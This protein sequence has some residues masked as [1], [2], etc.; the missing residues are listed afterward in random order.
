MNSHRNFQRFIKGLSSLAMIFFL[1][2]CAPLQPHWTD[3]T[4][5]ES[6]N[7]RVVTNSDPR[8]AELVLKEYAALLD[9][10]EQTQFSNLAS[11]PE[12]CTVYIFKN[13]RKFKE[14]LQGHRLSQK[15]QA[16]YYTHTQS[17]F[18]PSLGKYA[19]S[20]KSQPFWSTLRHEMVHHLHWSKINRRSP[21]W[22]SEG[23]AEWLTYNKT[24]AQDYLLT[25]F[26]DP[27]RSQQDLPAIIANLKA[28]I[29][30]KR[31]H[32]R[33][34]YIERWH[35]YLLVRALMEHAEIANRFVHYALFQASAHDS[36]KTLCQS[37][38]IS[39]E[40][41]AQIYKQSTRNSIR[42]LGHDPWV[43]EYL[44]LNKSYLQVHAQY[45]QAFLERARNSDPINHDK[46]QPLLGKLDQI[47]RRI[48]QLKQ[49]R[50]PVY[51][52][53]NKKR[54]QR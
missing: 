40:E 6:N 26:K 54:D 21:F 17:V 45:L 14:F 30:F 35:A 4:I 23:L 19:L 53:A 20:T 47:Q 36:L 38:K 10:V 32:D 33:K 16:F 49:K 7:L 51:K 1:C 39:I 41:L 22:L 24:P 46:L 28:L 8:V 3:P 2:G 31:T 12:P 37:L 50:N 29:S 48:A 15:I 44:R 34:E 52:I 9:Y 42:A 18:A 43:L 5:L 11:K 27:S 25:A 13:S